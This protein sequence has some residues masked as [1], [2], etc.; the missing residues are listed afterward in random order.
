VYVD[1]DNILGGR[2]PTV[3]KKKVN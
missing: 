2:L 1:Y 3:K